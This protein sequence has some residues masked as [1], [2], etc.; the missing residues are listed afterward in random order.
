MVEAQYNLGVKLY[1]GEG[2]AKDYG[3]AVRWYQLAAIQGDARAQFNLGG[4][5]RMGQG[6][7]QDYQKAVRWYRRAADQGDADAQSNLG[8]MYAQGRGVQQDY[9]EAIKW[10]RLA[11]EQG[12]AKAQSNLGFMYGEGRGVP[13]DFIL[14]HMWV[15]LAAK[16]GNQP[17]V[18]YRD[19][20]EKFLTP[21]QI[22]QA[23]R[24]AGEW[25]VAE[26][27]NVRLVEEAPP[28]E[29]VDRQYQ[30]A[31]QFPA[32][33]KLEK[34]PSPGEA[35]EVRVIVRHPV[36]PMYVTATVGHIGRTLTKQ[37]FESSPNRDTFVEA[38]MALTIERVYKKGSR[39]LGAEQ[40]IVSKKRVLP[41]DAG[42]G[43][44]IQTAHIHGNVTILIT[45]IHLVPFERP[46]MVSLIM[47]SPL[48]RTATRDNETITRIFNSFHLLDESAMK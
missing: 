4:M 16:Q 2:V 36:K 20:Y 7:P 47:T 33:W 15:N 18:K 25:K 12:F 48:D 22:A 26:K 9:G 40:M 41:S 28:R 6:V 46:D 3:E 10:Y 31:F 14:A 34:N 19:H 37:Q 11:A 24:L 17:A 30:F 5:Y 27:N 1:N 42:I 23:Q 8:V 43:F 39:L 35:G 13:Q 38:L 21:D 32:D 29:F 44:Y 45:G